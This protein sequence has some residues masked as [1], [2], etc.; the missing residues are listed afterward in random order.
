MSV[1]TN[2]SVVVE[3]TS[4]VFAHMG[5][6][7]GSTDLSTMGSH[8]SFVDLL[9][10]LDFVVKSAICSRKSSILL[11]ITL[12]SMMLSLTSPSGTNSN[13]SPL[14]FCKSVSLSSS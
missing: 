8:G 6:F 2:T 14:R 4:T 11:E 13:I 10:T 9:L 7:A 12:A 1:T 3:G 5:L